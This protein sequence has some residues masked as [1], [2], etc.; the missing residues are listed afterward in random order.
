MLK[1]LAKQFG[2]DRAIAY[3]VLARIV[4][5]G[6]GLL[7]IAL[8]SLFLTQEEQGFY[9]TFGSIAA[10]QIFFELGLNSIITQYV[11]HESVHLTWTTDQMPG[12]DPVHL[13]RLSSLLHFSI[14]VFSVLA[15]VIFIALEISG[16]YFFT[17][18]GNSEVRWQLPWQAI[19]LST[20]LM[21][22]INP[23][24]AFLEGLGKVK[25]VARMRLG[26][27]ILNIITIALVFLF[28]G[29]LLALGI[30]GLISFCYLLAC[31][32]L[33][34]YR[35]LLV[36]IYRQKGKW[37]VHY[38]KEIF[39]YQYKIA[40]SWVSGYFIFQL[41]NPVLFAMEGAVVA[42]QMGMTLAALSGISTLSM[43]W[44]NTKVPLF[45][46]MIAQQKFAE[47][48][49]VFDRTTKQLMLANIGLIILFMVFVLGMRMLGISLS[50]RFLPMWAL[51]LLSATIV[52]NQLVFSWATYLRCHK[53][54]PY[55]LNS[56]VGGVL[57]AA[58]TF[59]LG[60]RFGL[61]GIVAG[62][63]FLTIIIGLPWAY[64]VFKKRKIQWH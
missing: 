32:L 56:I 17:E 50:E 9:Y 2:V 3:T 18:Y 38:W 59:F 52:A 47:L 46:G 61:I 54:E 25:E 10:I 58:S 57:C 29:N 23:V 60:N 13:S 22:I 4:Q 15:L 21:M 51:I 40:L 42:G 7:L 49:V 37:V 8:I 27:S 28:H 45:S 12:G 14:K 11:A 34:H 48:D 63:T 20:S 36:F 62:Y 55:L 24:L 1:T 39:P 6:G 43:S 5:A 64:I 41:F 16:Y 19:A 35:S 33:S 30:A 26:Q 31:V 44:I 53:Q